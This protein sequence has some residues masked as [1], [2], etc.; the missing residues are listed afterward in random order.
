MM[1]DGNGFWSG[2]HSA[3]MEALREEE[4]EAL[5][6]LLSA[7]ESESDPET[8]RGL[9]DQIKQ[10]KSKFKSK[11]KAAGSSLYTKA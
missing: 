9:N 5:A 3:S 11:R 1:K 10:I 4:Q 6:P 7:L 8:K 2:G